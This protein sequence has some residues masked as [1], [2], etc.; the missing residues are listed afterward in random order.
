MSTVSY[1][2]SVSAAAPTAAHPNYR[3][4]IDGLR[5][6]A[7]IAVLAF[8]VAPGRVTGGFVGVDIFFVISGFLISSLILGELAEGRFS[9]VGFYVRRIRRIFPALFAV[10]AASLAVGLVPAPADETQSFG[11]ACR[12][13]AFFVSNLLFLWSNRLLRRGAG[14]KPLLHPWSLRIEEQF[15]IVWPMLLGSRGN[16]SGGSKAG[17]SAASPPCSS[18]TWRCPCTIL[19]RPSTCRSRAS[20]SCS[21]ARSWERSCAAS[22]GTA[23]SRSGG[24]GHRCG[25]ST[26][27]RGQAWH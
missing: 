13:R 26:P 19:R 21:S 1:S 16:G 22:C 14:R 3:A 6:V 18:P 8:H 9:L 7:V 27:L 11:T 24:R 25:S 12:R 2:T 10:L 17:F 15:Y 4:D 23:S 20:G 5:A